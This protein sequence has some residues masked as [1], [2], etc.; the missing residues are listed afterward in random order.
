MNNP[1]TKNDVHVVI[2]S[3]LPA[4]NGSLRL[5]AT[6]SNGYRATLTLNDGQTFTQVIESGY[7]AEDVAELAAKVEG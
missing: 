2:V 5:E 3:A 4:I 6:R 1:A 7:V